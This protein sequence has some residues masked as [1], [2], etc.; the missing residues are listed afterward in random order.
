MLL[1]L[2]FTSLGLLGVVLAQGIVQL[3]YNNW[4]WPK[5]VLDD[6]DVNPLEFVRQ[7]NIGL[8]DLIKRYLF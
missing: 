5:Y 6:L 3:S 4:R 2:R 8:F 7:G 1:S